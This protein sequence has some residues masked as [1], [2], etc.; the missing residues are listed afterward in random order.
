MA[1][2]IL[3]ACLMAL[4]ATT[5]MGAET[6]PMY[7][8]IWGIPLAVLDG[9]RTGT[10]A[11]LAMGSALKACWERVGPTIPTTLSRLIRF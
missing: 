5:A 3:S 6:R 4:G 1:G 9:P 2:F 7:S 11:R 8:P 10:L